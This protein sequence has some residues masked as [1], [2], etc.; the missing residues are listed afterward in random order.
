MKNHPAL[1]R[2]GQ[3]LPGA[4]AML[5]I[6]AV[7]VPSMVMWIQRENVFASKQSMNT[8]AFH[9]AEAGAE[10]AYLYISL[11]TITWNAIQNGTAQD[12]YRFDKSY[13]DIVGGSY[14]ISITSGPGTQQVT[15]VTVGRDKYGKETR[16][17]KLVYGNTIL[18]DTA[19]YSGRGAQISGGAQVHWGGVMSPSSIDATSRSYPQ[20]WS[21]SSIIGKD[22]DPNPSNCDCQTPPDCG[23]CQWHSY[24]KSLPSPPLIDFDFYR[25]SAAATMKCY[26]STGGGTA[27]NTCYFPGNVTGWNVDT[28]G[29]MFVEGDLTIVSNGMF[30]TGT[31]IVMGNINLPAGAWGDGTVNMTMP[32]KA[33]KQ[34]CNDWAAY[35]AYGNDSTEDAAFPG[36]ESTYS[37]TVTALQSK[38]VAVDGFLYVGGNFNNGGG[39]GGLSDVYGVMYAV[40]TSTLSNNSAV[41]FY[42]NGGATASL[43]T[44]NVSL[45]RVSW[46]DVLYGWPAGL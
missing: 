37:A 46:Q 31:M 6:L 2:R 27:T 3:I 36:L 39:G 22:T 12:D 21:A 7:M 40:G 32:V 29:T 20:F 41:G 35:R 28:K 11:S 10:K 18:G 19:I 1:N 44:T 16:A 24:E 42:Y 23:C 13:T 25:T 33:W 14:A 15:I 38:K 45:T 43:V 17:L 30:H 34:Y 8:T 4:V 9:M 26:N 5:V